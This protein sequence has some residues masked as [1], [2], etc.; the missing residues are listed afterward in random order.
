MSKK[1]TPT[2]EANRRERVGS[3]YAKRLR[4]AGRLP[5][6][7]YGHK[8]DP[9]AVDV[10]GKTTLHHLHTGHRILNVAV[11]GKEETCIVKDLQ[12]SYLGDEVIHLDFARIDLSEEVTFNARLNFVGTPVALKTDGAI[13]RTVSDTIELRCKAS[14]VLTEALDVDIT[15][16]EADKYM[17]IGEVPLPEGFTAEGDP[18]EIVCRIALVAEEAA[19]PTEEVEGEPEIISE[20]TDGEEEAGEAESES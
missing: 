13:F 5:A 19:E 1:E 15:E 16:L 9:V 10:D 14:D 17:T 3:R 11:E 20:S 6:V 12:F 2:L 4:A 8:K 7:I 18:Q